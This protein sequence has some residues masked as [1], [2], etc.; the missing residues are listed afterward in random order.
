MVDFKE[1]SLTFLFSIKQKV[2]TFKK[3]MQKKLPGRKGIVVKTF[4]D[5]LASRLKSISWSAK[6]K[7][8]QKKN[9][10]PS[11]FGEYRGSKS[12]GLTRSN[13]SWILPSERLRGDDV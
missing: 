12:R 10:P 13:L 6:C 8:V 9:Y 3:R 2:I 1:F 5:L 7:P 11:S 4:R